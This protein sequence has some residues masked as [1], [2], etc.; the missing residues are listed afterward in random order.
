M[1]TFIAKIVG[2]DNVSLNLYFMAIRAIIVY[3][4]AVLFVRIGRRRFLAR[5]SSFDLVL[6][7]MLGSVVSRAITG[8]APFLPTLGAGLVLIGLHYVFSLITFYSSLFGGWIKGHPV[9]LIRDGEIQ[10]PEMRRSHLTERDL[11]SAIRRNAQLMSPR[12]AKLAIL[13]RNGEISVIPKERPPQEVEVAVKEGVQT[14]KI[15]IK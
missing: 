2:P 15:E 3:I 1:N 6:A 8:N 11:L 7:L 5:P 14:I 4:V 13:E 9:I 12:Q 10:W